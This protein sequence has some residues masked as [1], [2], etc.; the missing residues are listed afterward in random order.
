MPDPSLSPNQG[1]VP[2]SFVAPAPA[3]APVT[4]PDPAPMA[5]GKRSLAD[6][7]FKSRSKGAAQ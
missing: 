6:I 1:V 2:T 5:T 4:Q 3:T 7:L